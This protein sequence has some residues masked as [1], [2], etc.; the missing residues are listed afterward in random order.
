VLNYGLLA[1]SEICFDAILPVY[2]ASS[3]LSLTPR[4]IGVFMGGVGAVRGIFQV[5]CTA[6]LVERLGA[7]RIYQVG[8][9]AYFPL[10][11]L[12]P[13]AVDMVSGD[14][15]WLNRWDVWL[16]AVISVILT[17]IASMAFSKYAGLQLS[18]TIA[19]LL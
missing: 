4:A 13:I 12:L 9:C 10:W 18:C 15:N 7:K 8:I 3:P 5:L 6:G 11:A 16:F 2:L 17:T 19:D 14:D 1:L